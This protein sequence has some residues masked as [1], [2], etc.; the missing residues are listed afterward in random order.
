MENFFFAEICGAR[1]ERDLDGGEVEVVVLELVEGE[2]VLEAGEAGGHGLHGGGVH[3]VH[4]GFL[5]TVD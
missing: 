1:R 3:S 2:A 5:G 4:G